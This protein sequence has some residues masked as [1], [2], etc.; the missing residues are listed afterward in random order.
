MKKYT[1]EKVKAGRSKKREYLP[2]LCHNLLFLRFDPL[3][4]GDLP[5]FHL[6]AFRFI[7]IFFCTLSRSPGRYKESSEKSN[8]QEGFKSYKKGYTQKG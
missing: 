5:V 6:S 2:Y 1:L 8:A 3:F 4:L 7:S